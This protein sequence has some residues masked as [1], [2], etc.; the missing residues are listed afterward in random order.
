MSSSNSPV[1][2]PASPSVD[3]I[4]EQVRVAYDLKA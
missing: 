2:A 4:D 3:D 1:G